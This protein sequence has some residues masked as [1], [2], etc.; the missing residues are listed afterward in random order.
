VL[1]CLRGSIAVVVDDGHERDQVVL[2]GPHL[3]LYVPPMVWT[4]HYRYSP[5]ALLLVLASDVYKPEDYIRSYDEFIAALSGNRE[6]Y[7]E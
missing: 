6:P 4:I 2:E 3:G 7:S 1:V 5:D